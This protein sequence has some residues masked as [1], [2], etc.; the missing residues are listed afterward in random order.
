MTTTETT[1]LT[2]SQEMEVA[3]LLRYWDSTAQDRFNAWICRRTICPQCGGKCDTRSMRSSDGRPHMVRD[4][5]FNTAC[6]WMSGLHEGYTF[7][8]VTE[9]N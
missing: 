8:P 9:V 6:E 7:R 1:A 3:H 5:C 2:A 4:E